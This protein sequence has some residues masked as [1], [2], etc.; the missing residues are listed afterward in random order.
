MRATAIG[1]ILSMIGALV[2]GF[3]VPRYEVIRANGAGPRAEGRGRLFEKLAWLTIFV[4][5]ALQLAD[6]L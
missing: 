1:L 4:G 2:L 3:V 5:F 6:A